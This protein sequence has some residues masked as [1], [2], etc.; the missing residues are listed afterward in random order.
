MAKILIVDDEPLITA[1][2]EDWLSE[3]G[4]VVV[5]PAHNLARALDLANSDIDAAVVDVSLGRD[6]S[7]P[8]V[9][10]LIG[11]GLPLA[12]A[13]GHG[14]DGIDPRYRAQSTLRKPFDFATFRRTVDELLEK[15]RPSTGGENA[16]S[17]GSTSMTH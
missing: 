2:M 12:L 6:N 3:L 7:Y 9:E 1:M 4:H 11:R 13:T 17:R 16:S 5:G 15:S 14:Q 10:A 8:L